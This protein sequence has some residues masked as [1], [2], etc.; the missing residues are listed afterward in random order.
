MERTKA[1]LL[2]TPPVSAKPAVPK[3]RRKLQKNVGKHRSSFLK[4]A[5]SDASCDE[6]LPDNKPDTVNNKATTATPATAQQQPCPPKPLPV[7]NL[8]DPK[9]SEYIR[10]SASLYTL[11]EVSVAEESPE[12]AKV[13]IIPELSHLAIDD[14]Q[15][16]HRSRSSSPEKSP[17]TTATTTTTMRRRRAKTPIF[18]IYQL[19]NIPRPGNALGSEK[20][21]SAEITYDPDSALASA[22]RNSAEI[23]A[24]QYRALLESRNSSIFYDCD[25]EQPESPLSAHQTG[26][27]ANDFFTSGRTTPTRR[28]SNHSNTVVDGGGSPTTSDAGTLVAFDEETVYFKPVSF[29]PE[30][31]Q[32][33]PLS[34][35]LSSPSPDFDDEDE[36]RGYASSSSSSSSPSRSTQPS[37]VPSDL[38]LQICLDF[39]MRDLTSAL[40]GGFQNQNQN[41]G[42]GARDETSALQV[43]VMIEAYERLRDRLMEARQ[44]RYEDKRSVVMMFDTWLRALYRIHDGLVGEG[45][46]DNGEGSGSG[47]GSD[48]EAELGVEELD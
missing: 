38:S 16:H 19:E 11:D 42:A 28:R 15:Q 43:W 10:D 7:P 34:M 39:L 48:Y 27:G 13:H 44:L 33:W 4:R 18:S 14:A 5:G 37:P 30:P 36:R 41:R 47:S 45:D 12:P 21:L 1:F 35:S 9:W 25:E 31:Q 3:L 8:S 32:P 46:G 20:R 26:G 6:P 40:K 23:M 22:K 17:Q 2:A 29:S 24:E